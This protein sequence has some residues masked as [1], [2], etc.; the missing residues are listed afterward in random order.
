MAASTVKPDYFADRPAIR[1]RPGPSVIGQT[2]SPRTPRTPLLGRSVSSQFGSPGSFRSEQDEIVVYELGARHLS[3]GLAGESRPRCI[4]AFGPDDSRR[5]GDYRAYAPQYQAPNRGSTEDTA[6]SAPFELYQVDLNGVDLGLFKDR[7]ERAV[8]MLHLADL[9]LDQKPRK[10][11]LV[12]PSLFPSPLLAATLEVIFT[13]STQPSTV[14]LLTTPVLATIGAGLRDALVIDIGWGETCV[15]AVGEFKNVCQRRSV[16][17]GKS[18][19]KEAAGM[20]QAQTTLSEPGKSAPLDF[21]IAE[22][23]V[24][25]LAW[26]HTRSSSPSPSDVS[27]VIQIPL[28][29]GLTPMTVSVE[30][31]KLSQPV[32]SV[33]FGSSKPFTQY[34]DHDLPLHELAYRVLVALPLDFRALCVS[35]VVITGGVS[36]LPG[37]KGRLLQEIHHM[38]KTRGWDPVHNYGSAMSR[39]ERTSTQRPLDKLPRAERTPTQ[40]PLNRLPEAVLPLALDTGRK[41]NTTLVDQKNPTESLV[42]HNERVHDDLKDPISLKAERESTKRRAAVAKGVIRGVDTVGP[43]AG[44]SLLASMRVKGV[45]EVNREDFL[46]HGLRDGTAL[47]L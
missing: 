43:W 25:R 17:A 6:W 32:E 40:R 4:L 35:R 44:A 42:A 2:A 16:R 47:W 26:C 8:R 29:R 30:Y 3:A 5:T 33:L 11:V 34:D 9:Q 1:A 37:L 19:T 39:P 24:K 23:V 14:S 21:E 12:I 22:D 28:A 45:H 20:L 10:A 46:K 18:L 7:L 36:Q 27:R 41:H 13:H 15:T 31:E 38:I